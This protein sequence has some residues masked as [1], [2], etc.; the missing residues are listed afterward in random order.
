[1]TLIDPQKRRTN[2]ANLCNGL[3]TS[4]CA[5]GPGKAFLGPRGVY[6]CMQP[7]RRTLALI[8]LGMAVLWTGCHRNEM[9]IQHVGS[10]AEIPAP[11]PELYVHIQDYAHWKNPYLSVLPDGVG[12][13]CLAVAFTKKVPVGA[14]HQTLLSLPLSAWPYGRVVALQA[15]GG[16]T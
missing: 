1:M 3:V 14:L 9:T 2:D 6:I 15:G 4:I 5:S 8:V 7:A 10:L 13:Q 11:M 12:I 16:P